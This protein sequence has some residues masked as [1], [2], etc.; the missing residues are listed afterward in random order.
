ML[1]LSFCGMYRELC[2]LNRTHWSRSFST[3]AVVV[4]VG[5]CCRGMC[6]VRLHW[7]SWFSQVLSFLEHSTSLASE[8]HVLLM[9]PI[10]LSSLRLSDT[11]GSFLLILSS[12]CQSA[13][14]LAQRGCLLRN[15]LSSLVWS[16]HKVQACEQ[17]W[18]KW[19]LSRKGSGAGVFPSLPMPEFSI[20]KRV[21]FC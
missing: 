2:F 8:P 11:T 14:P 12:D 15:R 16:E 1:P 18:Q 7:V 9:V 4:S 5:H 21:S 19:S 3:M 10:S 20:F 6:G 13:S 17:K